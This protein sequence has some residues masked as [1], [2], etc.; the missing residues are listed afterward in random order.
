VEVDLPEGELYEGKI[1]GTWNMKVVCSEFLVQ[2]G[3]AIAIE[4]VPSPGV[5]ILEDYIGR[6]SRGVILSIR[7]IS[8]VER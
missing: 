3:D 4:G 1:V 5:D 7:F 2:N 6:D 8:L